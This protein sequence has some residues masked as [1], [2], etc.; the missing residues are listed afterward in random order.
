MGN[1][2]R[3]NKRKKHMVRRVVFKHGEKHFDNM[4][5]G[6]L[7]AVAE[8]GSKIVDKLEARTERSVIRKLESISHVMLD[9]AGNPRTFPTAEDMREIDPGNH[10]IDLEQQELDL[11]TDRIERVRWYATR[12]AAALDTVDW[13]NA[14]EKDP[15]T[16]LHA[17]KLE[18]VEAVNGN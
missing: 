1:L 18:L 14:S 17:T 3:V 11:I 15:S 13:L 4:W 2:A 7:L 12:R 9:A 6:V 8:P 16:P 10:V 5:G